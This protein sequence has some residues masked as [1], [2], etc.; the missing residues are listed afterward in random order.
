MHG[1]TPFVQSLSADS[2]VDA[3]IKGAAWRIDGKILVVFL[4]GLNVVLSQTGDLVN[5]TD[6]ID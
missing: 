3:L 6:L 1:K 4:K 5:I 2:V